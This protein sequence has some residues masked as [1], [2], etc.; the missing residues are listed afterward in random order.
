MNGLWW[1]LIVSLGGLMISAGRK[2][3]QCLNKLLGLK[4][5]RSSG[6]EAFKASFVILAF[7]CSCP[8]VSPSPWAWDLWLAS[9]QWDMKNVTDFVKLHVCDNRILYNHNIY[10]DG[11]SHSLAG[12]EEARCHVRGC[13]CW[14][15]HVANN[16]R[17][18]SRRKVT[19][20][21]LKLQGPEFC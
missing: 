12:L 7:W 14:K 2:G 6:T 9:N 3:V 20:S 17:I 21:V 11:I 15:A 16:S 10:L 18:D 13:L 8:C 5:I 4:R 19:P 1:L